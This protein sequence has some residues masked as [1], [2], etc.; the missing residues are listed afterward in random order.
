M[1][2]GI[3]PKTNKA[4]VK[5]TCGNT[6]EVG[7]TVDSISVEIC[8]K[9]HPFWTG[10]DKIV[11]LEGRVDKFKRKVNVAEKSLDV[12]NE[13]NSKLQIYIV[14]IEEN[15]QYIS[16]KRPDFLKPI[17]INEPKQEKVA[18]PP[19]SGDKTNEVSAFVALFEGAT[20]TQPIKNEQP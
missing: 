1:K 8:S 18:D 17:P 7:S 3:H 10:A 13:L 5:C 12:I 2:D 20:I 9:C 11:D 14:A 16:E 6:F 19:V 4:T 15:L